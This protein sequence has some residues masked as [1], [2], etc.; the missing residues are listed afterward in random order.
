MDEFSYVTGLLDCGSTPALQSGPSS[1]PVVRLRGLRRPA[2]D[3]S[4]EPI[5]YL[6]RDETP[7]H[8]LR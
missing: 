8:R 1:E 3:P 7:F 5:D 6:V 2:G 4:G